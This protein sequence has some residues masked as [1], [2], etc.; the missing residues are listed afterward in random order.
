MGSRRATPRPSS[1]GAG[2]GS[3]RSSARV[4]SGAD[5]W[6]YRASRA[7]G[8]QSNSAFPSRRCRTRSFRRRSGGAGLQKPWREEMTMTVDIEKALQTIA[9]ESAEGLF[10]DYGMALSPA[11]S[12]PYSGLKQE[13]FLCGIIGFTGKT[14][15]GSVMLAVERG[16]LEASAPLPTGQ[17]SLRDWIAELSNQLLGRIKRQLLERGV[18]IEMCTPAVLRGERLSP[19]LPGEVMPTLFCSD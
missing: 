8:P 4:K 18:T 9:M 5:A 1:R 2:S 6:S 15:R 11:A 16:L 7:M 12:D 13:F 17:V 3:A 10:A 19:M 14:L